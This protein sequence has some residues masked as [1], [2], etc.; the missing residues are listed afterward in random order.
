MNNKLFIIVASLLLTSAS[1][2]AQ[3][4][5]TVK[6]EY[7]K[8]IYVKQLYRAIEPD[9]YEQIKDRLPETALSY[10]DFIGNNEKSIYKPGRE[11]QYDPRSFYQGIADK[12][13]VYNDYS[14]GTYTSQKPVFEE[15]FLVQ[16]SLLRI[17]WK[18]TGDTRMIAGF[19]CRKAI[20]FIDDS[21][22]VFAF[23]TDE[24]TITGGP[25]SINGLPGLVLGLGMPRIHTTWFATKVEVNGVN[26]GS[27]VPASKG[28]K[29]NRKTMVESLDRVLKN[30]G[31]YGKNMVW[32]F[33]I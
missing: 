14:S 30:W 6:V 1:V 23:Y 20:G 2:N 18:L 4:F 3:F 17:K 10:F 9:W 31:A 13:V 16:D 5:N 25:E 26:T 21:I 22:A 8:T 7:E 19:E 12:N 32:N 15:T 33:V 11:V 28:K 27:I 24:I 29:V